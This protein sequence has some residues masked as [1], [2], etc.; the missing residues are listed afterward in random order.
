MKN[1]Y[2][3]SNEI[4]YYKKYYPYKYCIENKKTFPEFG[5]KILDLKDGLD[6]TDEWAY[7]IIEDCI[8][9]SLD[10]V[11][12]CIPTSEPGK[13]SML[14]RGASQFVEDNGLPMFVESLKRV[15]P[16][17]SQNGVRRRT[18]DEEFNSTDLHEDF[19]VPEGSI[20]LLDD[21]TTSGN[22]FRSARQH[23]I[24]A[25]VSSEKIVCF[26]LGFTSHF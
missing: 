24:N 1:C 16:V 18:F 15:L 3:T 17:E 21:I 10:P 23:L 13:T 8:D 4:Y 20:I 25:G 11:I 22:S 12:I 5:R 19:V 26:A 9:L 2:K 14:M 7:S 6:G